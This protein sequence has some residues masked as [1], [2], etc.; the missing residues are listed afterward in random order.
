MYFLYIPYIT[1]TQYDAYIFCVMYNK[2]KLDFP[3]C[4]SERA[5]AQKHILSENSKKKMKNK[6]HNTM[7]LDDIQQISHAQ[8]KH[9]HNIHIFTIYIRHFQM[10]GIYV[11][12]EF[13][14]FSK[15]IEHIE[16]GEH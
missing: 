5:L 2:F 13:Y 4:L 6:K 11:I 12:C 8:N 16:N 1:N 10:F 15:H 7:R 9:I 3:C 14:F